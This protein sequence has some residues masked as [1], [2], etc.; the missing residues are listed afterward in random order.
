MKW[1]PDKNP[2][3]GA[4]ENFRSI[5]DA[6]DILSNSSD[7]PESYRSMLAS[8]LK[9]NLPENYY[10]ENLVYVLEIAIKKLKKV[11]EKNAFFFFEN[12]N[13]ELLSRIYY[14]LWS[15]KE[16]FFLS[17]TFFIELKEVLDKKT[18]VSLNCQ[19]EIIHPT[20]DDLFDNNLYKIVRNERTYL[21]PLWHH[22]LIYDNSGAELCIKCIPIIPENITIDEDNHISI[23]ITWNIKDIWDKMNLFIYIGCNTFCILR[24]HLLLKE[25][26]I[27]RLYGNG[28]SKINT[29]D[30]YDISK[31]GDIILHIKLIL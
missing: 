3:E 26:Q 11:Y 21:V 5:K 2:M 4:I 23:E 8:F 7:I 22:E 25:Y 30:V 24:E 29:K 14:I 15:Y 28:I 1:H 16:L 6:Y 13:I 20:I 18:A 10:N 19:I 12:M 31:K 27:I 17:D 9:E